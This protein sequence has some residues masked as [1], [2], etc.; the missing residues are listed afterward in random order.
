M[1]LLDKFIELIEKGEPFSFS[2]W[3]DGEWNAVFGKPGQNCDGHQYFPDMG[4]RLSDILKSSPKYILGLQGLAI[5]LMPGPINEYTEKY[6]LKW[7][8]SD[9]FHHAN[10]NG[11]IERFWECIRTKHVLIVGP[12]HLSNIKLFDFQLYQIPSRNCWLA[13][14]KILNDLKN[15]IKEDTL[16]LFCASMMANVLIDELDGKGILID[17]GSVLD[18]HAGVKSRSYHRKMEIK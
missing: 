4:K 11:Q 6:N 5:R 17:F 7:T 13:H 2:R 16:V 1:E 9:V 3:G 12:A 10:Q 8:N 14:D 15:I 18:P